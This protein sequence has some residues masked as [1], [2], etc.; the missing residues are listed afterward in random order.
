MIR[1]TDGRAGEGLIAV[2]K[3]RVTMV[4]SLI[5]TGGKVDALVIRQ[6]PYHQRSRDQLVTLINFLINLSIR[7]SYFPSSWKTAVVIPVFKSGERNTP[8]N[9]RP[10]SI[11]PVASKIAEKIVCDQLVSPLNEGN[12]SLHPMQFGFRKHYSTET[13]NC[14]ADKGGVVGA[15]FL[16]L[17]KAFDTVNHNILLSKLSKFNLS[18]NALTW[19]ESYLNQRKQCTRVCDKRS[20]F[21]NCTVGV[22]QGSILGPIL[23]SIYINDLPQVCP[24]VCTQ[25]YADTVIFTHARNK[26]D[27]AA[28]LTT[29]MSKV[30]DWLANSCLT[31]NVSKTTCMYFTKRIHNSVNPDILINGEVIKCVTHVKYL[32]IEIDT[33]LSFKK[34]VSKV[35][36]NV[37]FNLNNFKSIRHQL[38]PFTA[39]LFVQTMI[40]PHLSYCITTWSQAGVTVLKP[41]YSLYKHIL[42]ALDKKP[43]D[44]HHSNV[45]KKYDFLDFDNFMF[46]SDV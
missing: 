44:Y 43:K 12:F 31:L 3:L 28:N 6:E 9:Y 33:N 11:L 16:D 27:V 25:M 15:V 22:P 35:I 46:H 8:S 23:F 10:I 21:T 13:A 42:K 30:S 2:L 1:L 19:M 26:D 24:D 34:Q 7:N 38:S 40:F 32:G 18:A 37:K 29:A 41:V 4:K 20:S 14:F 36:K 39:K 45:L 17:R 5:T